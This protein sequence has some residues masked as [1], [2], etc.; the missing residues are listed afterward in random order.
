MLNELTKEQIEAQKKWTLQGI[1]IGLDTNPHFDKQVVQDLVNKHRQFWGVP[2]A[3]N[4]LFFDSPFAAIKKISGIN[5]GNALYGSHDIHWLQYYMYYKVECNLQGLEGIQYLHKLATMV[6]WMWMSSDTA[7]ITR[8][9][10]Q[11]H[12]ITKN[13]EN[14]QPGFL[15]TIKVLHNPDGKALKYLDET[16]VYVMN[17]IRITDEKHI[18]LI[19]TPADQ[20]DLA[21]VFKIKN[22]EIRTEFIKKVGISKAISRME[23]RVLDT[24]CLEVGGEYKL[25]ELQLGNNKRVYLQGECPSNNEVFFNAVSPECKT[26]RQA[27]AWRRH[28]TLS[29]PFEP[30]KALT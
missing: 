29:M 12:T 9:P 10:F 15:E 8:K 13:L 2:A 27:L 4:F 16:G 24:D 6:G 1:K 17:G 26:V 3:E 19:H 18:K 7:I 21:D 28:N 14:A 5:P 25:Y 11:M 23:H 22:T 20:I 30:P